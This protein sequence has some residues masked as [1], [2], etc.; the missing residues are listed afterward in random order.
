MKPAPDSGVH[1]L[2]NNPVHDAMY[3]LRRGQGE[4]MRP[5]IFDVGANRGQS[6]GYFKRLIPGSSV[7]SFEPSP[8]TFQV[9]KDNTAH[10]ENVTL[11]NVGLGSKRE[12][13]S[14]NQ[15]NRSTMSSFLDFGPAS[16]GGKESQ[17]PV[18]LDTLD[19]Y[20]EDGKIPQIDLLKIDTQGFDLEVLKGGASI[21]SK[22]RVRLVLTEIILSNMYVGLPSISQLFD[23]MTSCRMSLVS[24][25]TQHYRNDRIGW[26]DALFASDMP[27][28]AAA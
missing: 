1:Q 11:N 20:V 14:F 27:V 7:H 23:Y 4:A 19:Q 17:F 24:F 28:V 2:G 26:T 22:G 6:V 8:T 13:R 10:L 18:Q 9:L 5:V 21:L 16:W 3:L 25:Y 12:L 15:G